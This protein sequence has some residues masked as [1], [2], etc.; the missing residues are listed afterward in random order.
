[1]KF[2]YLAKIDNGDVRKGFL[3]AQSKEAAIETLSKSNLIPISINEVTGS[4]NFFKE[5]NDKT[6]FVP[7]KEK[8]LL[9]RQLSTL[10]SAG[11]P[12]SQSMHILATQVENKKLKQAVLEVSE[13]IEGGLALSKALEK[14]GKLFSRLVI[15]MVKAGEV[16]GILDESLDRAAGQLEKEHEL[17]SQIRGAMI[18]PVAILVLTVAVLIFMIIYLIPQMSGI[19][20]SLGSELPPNLKALMG[21]SEFI[22]KFGVL[23]GIGIGGFIYGFRFI[24]VKYQKA[25]LLW[26]TILL[27]F[28]VLGKII[29]KINVSRFTRNLS[30]LLSSGVNILEA[31]EVSKDS[32]SNEVYTTEIARAIEL[33]KNGSSIADA[34]KES[35]YFPTVVCQTIAVGEETGSTDKI[36]IKLTEYY[37]NEVSVLTK[38]LS[39]LILPIM[40]VLIGVV[41]GLIFYSVI[42]PLS[43][44]SDFIS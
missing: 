40:M 19:F 12:I 11:I 15:N 38:G 30:A 18:Y 39:D 31:L 28:P 29:E 36:L 17:L 24:L 16:G 1:M 14:Q 43:Q 33:V 7:F 35:P 3:E 2:K 23:V 4:Q 20:A 42:V 21:F 6:T 37:E 9:T 26:H 5:I 25:R 13:D 10:I 27:K 8:V 44:I 34:L 22:K 32:L 41:V